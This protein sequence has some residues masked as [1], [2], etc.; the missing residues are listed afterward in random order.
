MASSSCDGSQCPSESCPT[1]SSSDTEMPS[2]TPLTGEEA[3]RASEQQRLQSMLCEAIEEVLNVLNTEG[4]SVPQIQSIFSA[5]RLDPINSS[6]VGDQ[7]VA[8]D[9][10][11][12]NLVVT[13]CESGVYEVQ[14]QTCGARMSAN[15]ELWSLPG[16]AAYA[17]IQ[18]CDLSVLHPQLMI[19]QVREAATAAAEVRVFCR[20]F[21]PSKASTTHR[22]NL[23]S[24]SQARF[25]YRMVKLRD[26]LQS[27]S[28]TASTPELYGACERWSRQGLFLFQDQVCCVWCDKPPTLSRLKAANRS[29]PCDHTC[30]GLAPRAHL[31]ISEVLGHGIVGRVPGDSSLASRL[32]SLSTLQISD[33][34]RKLPRELFD[35]DT[36]ELGDMGLVFSG[37]S[38]LMICCKCLCLCAGLSVA[39]FRHSCPSERQ[40]A[41]LIPMIC[42]SGAEALG[43]D[44]NLSPETCTSENEHLVYLTSKPQRKRIRAGGA[45]KGLSPETRWLQLNHTWSYRPTRLQ[46]LSAG[47]WRTVELYNKHP[48]LTK[49]LAAAGELRAFEAELE[50]QKQTKNSKE[51]SRLFFV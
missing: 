13:G 26:R 12:R 2:E 11:S 48:A 46:A 7:D 42:K 18:R 44:I 43:M 17:C 20:G 49:F 14:C 33:I 25:P 29:D 40:A 30:D 50:K 37:V 34:N 1:T 22:Y 45:R 6:V 51:M 39:G 8:R 16:F 35:C 32:Q 5:G 3:Q 38:D 10:S 15:S 4:L 21:E 24:M 41:Q 9:L 23:Y 36:R 47:H 27:W 31:R 28:S 19:D